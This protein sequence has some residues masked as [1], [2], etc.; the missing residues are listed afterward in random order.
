M[1][2]G[3]KTQAVGARRK[4][5]HRLHVYAQ[6][7]AACGCMGQNLAHQI[8]IYKMHPFES[9]SMHLPSM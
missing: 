6:P 5:K 8:S 4:R 9:L 2:G 1:P 3:K 7:E